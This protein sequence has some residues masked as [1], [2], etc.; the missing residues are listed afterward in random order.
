M[1]CWPSWSGTLP[2][3]DTH[4]PRP[5]L[6][7]DPYPTLRP[8]VIALS[9][10]GRLPSAELF[11]K[12]LRSMRRTPINGFKFDTCGERKKR[13]VWHVVPAAGGT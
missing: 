10:T 12:K 2:R 5:L 13:T 11:G 4:D 8:A 6:T 7:S 1:R 3:W 9:R